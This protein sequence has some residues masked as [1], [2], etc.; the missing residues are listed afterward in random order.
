[1]HFVC[2]QAAVCLADCRC[3]LG[4]S[5]C[6]SSVGARCQT[7]RERTRP[8]GH[9]PH[10]LGKWFRGDC[11]GFQAFGPA[12]FNNRHLP[13]GFGTW[14]PGNWSAGLPTSSNDVFITTSASTVQ[15]NVTATIDNLTIG[16]TDVLNFNN[17]N[18]LTIDGT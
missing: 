10:D 15:L 13:G 6:A 9:P 3:R 7:T 14:S 4:R 5:L 18:S 17:A 2:K 16:S 1:M 12:P 11:L 8:K